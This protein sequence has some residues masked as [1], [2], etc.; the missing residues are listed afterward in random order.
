M[1]DD[2]YAAYRDDVPVG[3]NLMAQ[4]MAVADEQESLESQIEE[5]EANLE[6]AK[7]DLREVA[8]KRLPALLDGLRGSLLLDDGR[9]IEI[10]EK[11]RA[12][13]AGAKA[14]PACEWLDEHG[15]GGLVKREFVIS[16]GKDD[17][18]WARKFQ[19]DLA[20]RKKPLAVKV[21][22]TVHHK[23][24][25]SWVNEQFKEGVDIPKD[26]FGV[27]RQRMAKVKRPE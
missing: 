1:T 22:R 12:S 26:V 17:E 3:P 27:Y 11:M 19:R 5:L 25:E 16:F 23:T 4:L 20:R 14:D 13:I 8:E 18:A 24:L 15:H 6:K 21:K 7:A 2:P 9:T 10:T